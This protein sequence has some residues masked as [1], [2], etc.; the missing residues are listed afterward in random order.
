L[1]S[2]DMVGKPKIQVD[3]HLSPSRR[4]KLIIK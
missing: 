3:Q 2:L 1:L 4:Q